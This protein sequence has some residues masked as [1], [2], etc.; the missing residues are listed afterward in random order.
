MASYRE[1]VTKAVIAKGKKLFTS[2]HEV[3]S[4]NKPSTILGVWVINHNFNGIKN[5]DEIRING[6]YDVNVWY[7]YDNDTKTEVLKET[8]QYSEIVRMREREEADDE[9][10]IV[11]SLKQP[12]CIKVDIDGDK[13]KYT[14]EKELGVELVGDVKVKVQADDDEDPWDEIIEESN[15]EVIQ[16]NIDNVSDEYLTDGI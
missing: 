4:T 10:I 9:Q 14:I 16:E 7:S 12:N 15:S 3:I 8:N 5:N 13:I 6:S 2:N 11:R 1:I